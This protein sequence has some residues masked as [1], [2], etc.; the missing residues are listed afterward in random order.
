MYINVIN[1]IQ[2]TLQNQTATDINVFGTS[3]F[4]GDIRRHA[5][6]D[7]STANLR[8]LLLKILSAERE[9]KA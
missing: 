3:A 6:R 4:A 2:S 1:K 5:A 7:V 9:P 8:N